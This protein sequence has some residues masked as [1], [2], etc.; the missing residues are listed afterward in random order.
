MKVKIFSFV[1]KLARQKSNCL[2]LYVEPD[3]DGFFSFNSGRKQNSLI[4]QR[5]SS[6]Q[7]VQGRNKI[8]YN[9]Q[10]VCFL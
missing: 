7:Y 9:L 2:V 3:G 10:V 1:Y 6:K 4:S 5:G 8:I